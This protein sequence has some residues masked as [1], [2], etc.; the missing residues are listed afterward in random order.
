MDIPALPEDI[1]HLQTMLEMMR[2]IQADQSRLHADQKKLLDRM[3]AQ[4]HDKK[5]N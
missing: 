1:D 4:G 5:G 3:E 2:D